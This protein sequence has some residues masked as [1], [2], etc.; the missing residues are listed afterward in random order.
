MSMEAQTGVFMESGEM[1]AQA[2]YFEVL[3]RE[4]LAGGGSV[5]YLP[6]RGVSMLPLLRQG[7]SERIL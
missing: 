1:F 6:F 5:G 4:R 3:I 2:D 7:N